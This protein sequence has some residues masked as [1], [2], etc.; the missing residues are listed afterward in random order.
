MQNGKTVLFDDSGCKVFNNKHE[1]VATASLVDNMY[2]LDRFYPRSFTVCENKSGESLWHRRMGHIGHSYLQKQKSC[3]DG[4]HFQ[5]IG[6][7]GPCV[8]CAKGKLSRRPFKSSD[9]RATELLELVH[10]DVCGPMRVTS[11]G[12]ARYFLIFLDDFSKKVFVYFIKSKS[13]VK[14]KFG[15]KP[16]RT[17]N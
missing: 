9:T 5:S 1:I 17:Q 12:G 11:H 15:R 2:K 3:V 8:V 4:V 10:S 13:E 16:N 14:Q 6:E 7:D